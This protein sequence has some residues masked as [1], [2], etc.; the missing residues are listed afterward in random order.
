MH[1]VDGGLPLPLPRTQNAVAAA[2]LAYRSSALAWLGRTEDAEA[3]A[4]RAYRAY[5]TEQGRR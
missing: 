1:H 2:L 4:R 3:E 5:R